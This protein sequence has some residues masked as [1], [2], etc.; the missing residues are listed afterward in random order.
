LAELPLL[1]LLVALPRLLFEA[2]VARFF[3][4]ELEPDFVGIVLSFRRA[5]PLNRKSVPLSAARQFARKIARPNFLCPT[6]RLL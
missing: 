1:E 6:D 2:E 4:V 5:Q 3:E